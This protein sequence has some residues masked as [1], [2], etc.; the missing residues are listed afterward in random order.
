MPTIETQTDPAITKMCSSEPVVMCD[1]A[2]QTF[3]GQ[4][5]QDEIYLQL[6]QRLEEKVES[7]AREASEEREAL[8]RQLGEAKE[9]REKLKQ[10]IRNIEE[11]WGDDMEHTIAKIVEERQE[12]SKL[13]QMVSKNMKVTRELVNTLEQILAVKLPINFD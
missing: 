3:N 2:T 10:R 11:R 6:Y 8:H 7:T 12:K 5:T 1:Q 13:Q 4:P 9:E